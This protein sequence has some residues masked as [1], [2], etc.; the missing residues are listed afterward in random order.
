MSSD[1]FDKHTPVRPPSVNRKM[2]PN[3]QSIGVVYLIFA[4]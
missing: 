2:N 3:T 4:P 1:E